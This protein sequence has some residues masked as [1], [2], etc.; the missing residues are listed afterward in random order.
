M[1]FSDLD[2]FPKL[3]EDY[4][5]RTSSS[6]FITLSC[7]II[8]IFLFISQTYQ[9]FN[10]PLTQ[11]IT[12]DET[13]LPTTPDGN[14][15][16]KSL[17]R[18][19]MNFN[20]TLYGIPCVFVNFG[21]LN[22]YKTTTEDSFSLVKLTRLTKD[23]Q[24]IKEPKHDYSSQNI[25]DN[26]PPV[27]LSCYGLRSGCCNTCKEVRRAYK[28]KGKIPPPLSQIEQCE[29]ESLEL[30]GVMNEMCQ[31]SGFISVPPSEGSFFISPADSY[32]E[33][34]KYIGD[35]LAMG[36]TI[37]DFNFSHKIHNF[38]VN[39]RIPY[40]YNSAHKKIM[41]SLVKRRSIR[42]PLANV[43]KI[44]HNHSRYKALYFIRA[45]KEVISKD[46]NKYHIDVTH[47]DRYRVGK[48]SKFPGLYFYY[49]VAPI[50]IE[51]KRDVSVL[52]FLVTLIGILGGIFALGNLADHLIPNSIKSPKAFMN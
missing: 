8:M 26:S 42:S 10:A 29:V 47:Y 34:T 46:I 30:A 21:I 18:L 19:T 12:V 51:Y 3:R 27:C 14:L 22:E 44:Q 7:I 48:S 41:K 24:I 40:R 17:P 1:P 33:R 20:I 15:D 23:G 39:D 9:Y 52:R 37:D 5:R 28:A 25:T 4:S 43:E 11:R 6:G 36:L 45:V 13:P 35:Y 50:M 32:G 38:Y 16:I 31:L 49:N 2:I